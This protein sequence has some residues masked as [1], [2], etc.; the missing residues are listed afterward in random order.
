MFLVRLV[1]DNFE[2]RFSFPPRNSLLGE[3]KSMQR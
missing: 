2:P 1:W 3:V